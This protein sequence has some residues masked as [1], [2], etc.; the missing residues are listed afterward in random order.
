MI[1]TG[2][3]YALS[4]SLDGTT[5]KLFY[6]V[7]ASLKNVQAGVFAYNRGATTSSLAVGFDY[8]RLA[9]SATGSGGVGGTV[10]S[11]LSLTLGP[12]AAFGPFTPGVAKD[13]SA[14]TT[15]DVISTAGD[16]TLS[17]ADPS[18]TA[19]GH[20]VN[21]AFSLPSALTASATSPAGDR[22]RAG[23]G[24]GVR[25]PDDATA[26]RRAGHPRPGGDRVRPAHRRRRPAAHGDLRQDA[27]VHPVHHEPVGD[28]HEH[29]VL[30]RP[31]ARRAPPGLCRAARRRRAS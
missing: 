9:T 2:Q 3:R 28:R 10:P 19:T 26:L 29:A 14:T 21:G 6:E 17:V 5:W 8:F 23:G 12:A 20:L 15:A 11:Q 30:V 4:Y 18:G 31:R 25:E 13:Y 16:A 7:G 22:L 27:H 24:R 1:K